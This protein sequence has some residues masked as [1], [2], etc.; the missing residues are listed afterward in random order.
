MSTR[1]ILVALALA[2]AAAATAEAAGTEGMHNINI[3]NL[4]YFMLC[5][6]CITLLCLLDKKTGLQD[7]RDSFLSWSSSNQRDAKT[8]AR[9]GVREMAEGEAGVMMAT[10]P[11]VELLKGETMERIR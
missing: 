3:N 4:F 5:E 8:S 10:E 6:N 1:R 7:L 11:A 2:L 9:L